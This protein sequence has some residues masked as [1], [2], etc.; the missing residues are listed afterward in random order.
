MTG[1]E[2]IAHVYFL[3]I[4]GIGMSALARWFRHSG[5]SVAGYDRTP[6]LLTATLEK[7]GIRVHYSDLGEEIREFTG[8][9]NDTLVVV[10]PALPSDHGEWNW[11]KNNGYTILKRSKVLGM[12]CNPAHSIAVAGTHGKT[13]VSTMAATILKMSP[14]GCGA[15]LGGISKNFGT[16]LLLPGSPEEWLV[17]EADEYDR[18]FLQLTPEVAVITYMDADHLDIYENYDEV[19]TSFLD[20]ASGIK[21]GGSLVVRRE[22]AGH[23]PTLAG[24]EVYTYALE[25]EAS[26]VTSD[27]TL[28][29]TTRNYSFRIR[30]PGG[31]TPLI[32]MGYPGLHNV[33]NA[34]AAAA[35][36]F[37]AGARL[38]DIA[39]GLAEYT[40]V[41]RRFDIRHRSGKCIYIDDYAHHPKE[42]KTFI[43]SVRQMWP[44]KKITGI[45]Q[46]HLY[47]RTRDFST[48]F[49]QSLDLLDTAV[50]L[51][52]YPARELPI[53]GVSAELILSQMTLADKRMAEKEEIIPCLRKQNP[54]LLLTMGAGDIELL[55][56]PIMAFLE[57]AV[58]GI[59][60]TP[61]GNETD[62]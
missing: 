58:N 50:I 25:G 24:K 4:G 31:E 60:L 53:P 18:S 41:S 19:V 43:T 27:L 47:S 37:L 15:I 29:A 20:F 2:N 9:H 11:L 3:G 56:D 12:I 10:T 57:E 5:L 35:A 8:H 49:A 17:T 42:L 38:Q 33:E 34:I 1:M 40:G 44:E 22:L 48:E 13:T 55:A 16:N 30:T 39:R 46:P 26:F 59:P 36:S 51:P 62:G 32:T 52:I 28:D 54:E 23:F 7:E 14:R 61:H 21:S 6:S 45:F